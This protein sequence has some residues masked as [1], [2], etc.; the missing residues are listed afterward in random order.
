AALLAAIATVAAVLRTP[1][2]SLV[3]PAEWEAITDYA[4]SVSS[5]ALSADGRML[6]FLRG[7]RTLIT[8]GDVY[9]MVLPKGPTLQL[10]HDESQEKADPVFSTDGSTVAYTAQFQ[11]WTVPVAGGKPQPWLPNAASLHW[12]DANML[13]FSTLAGSG[14]VRGMAIATSDASRTRERFVY[15]PAGPTA[16]AHR[17][18]LSPDRKWVRAA[19]EM[20]RRPPWRWQ[21]C[22]IVPFDGSSTGHLIGPPGAACTAGAWSPDGHWIYLVTNAGGGFHVWRQRFPSGAPEQ[23]TAG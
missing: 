15:T 22:R 4:D 19:A 9:V 21:P 5:P 3:P 10:T 23:L 2:S 8:T 13:L 11:T 14:P 7:P 17:S 6:A 12:V 1:R 20:V 18:Y 16:M